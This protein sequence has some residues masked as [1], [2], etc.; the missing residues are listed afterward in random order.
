MRDPKISEGNMDIGYAPPDKDV[1]DRAVGKAMDALTPKPTEDLRERVR[2]KIAED[3]ANQKTADLLCDL[4][5]GKLT[6]E[7]LGFTGYTVGVDHAEPGS[8]QTVR[9]SVRI[10]ERGNSVFMTDISAAAPNVT[11]GY[12]YADQWTPEQ[13][14]SAERGASPLVINRIG[15]DTYF[16]QL[17]RERQMIGL[18]AINAEAQAAVNRMRSQ[19]AQ[20]TVHCTCNL[21]HG[22]VHLP[23]CPAWRPVVTSGPQRLDLDDEEVFQVRAKAYELAVKTLGNPDHAVHYPM[24][25]IIEKAQQ[26]EQ[27]L[28]TGEAPQ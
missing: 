13:L 7:G 9:T 25:R 28:L 11:I 10:D 12:G 16:N 1:I 4:R 21:P 18:A 20:Q 17:K 26:I 6:P 22:G 8:E 2:R 15:M 27:Y 14:A 3:E 19:E 23:N 24:N 5:D